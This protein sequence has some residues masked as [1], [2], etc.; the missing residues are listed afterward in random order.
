MI[1][2]YFKTFLQIE[3]YKSNLEQFTNIKG[4]NNS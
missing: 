1:T 2:L 3:T 4:F